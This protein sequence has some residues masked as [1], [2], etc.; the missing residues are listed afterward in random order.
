[1]TGI[2]LADDH[3]VVRR[4][5]RA[6]LEAERDFRIVGETGDGLEAVT[7]V[8]R[9]QP[10]VLVVDLMMPG[11]GG[12]EVARQTTRVAPRTRIVVLSMHAAEGYV[13]EALRSG[14][15]G[16]VLKDAS[17]SELVHAVREVVAG[18]HYLSPALSRLAI[19]EYVAKAKAAPPDA[20]H[21]L[22]TR[23][24][25]VLHLVA[26]G[27]TSGQIARRLAISARTAETH[28]ANLRKKLGLQSTADLT[29]YA[30]ERGLLSAETSRPP[31]PDPPK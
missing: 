27:R 5:L 20:Y 16:Y 26:E 14:A 10:D 7:A 25:E 1:V 11:L 24:R 4:G 29:R 2:L 19:D 8:E 23:E 28:R 31:A 13:L 15:V 3:A 21:T 18:R 9:L 17:P 12:L 22:T 6:L 30:L